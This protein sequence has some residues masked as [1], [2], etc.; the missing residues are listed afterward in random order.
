VGPAGAGA[1]APKGG[2]PRTG[3]KDLVIGIAQDLAE[4]QLA[5]FAGS[6]REWST[7]EWSDIVVSAPAVL[8]CLGDCLG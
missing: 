7:S 4:E 8:R 1:G 3:A 6:W 5:V 2:A